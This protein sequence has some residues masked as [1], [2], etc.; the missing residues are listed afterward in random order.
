[1]SIDDAYH[2]VI[3][4]REVYSNKQVVE[5]FVNRIRRVV[6]KKQ[7]KWFYRLRLFKLQKDKMLG[8]ASFLTTIVRSIESRKTCSGFMRLKLN[9]EK[10]NTRKLAAR[11]LSSLYK[12]KLKQNML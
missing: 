3:R 2:F 5:S 4:Q 6:A 1:M 12:R 10:F 7:L 9:L 8:T 11:Q